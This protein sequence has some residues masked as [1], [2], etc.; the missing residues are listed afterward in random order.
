MARRGWTIKE[1]SLAVVV[2]DSWEDTMGR[3]GI[4]IARR[5]RVEVCLGMGKIPPR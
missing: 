2:V 1:D 5:E 4:G 3:R